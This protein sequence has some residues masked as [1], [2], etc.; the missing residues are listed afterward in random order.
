MPSTLKKSLLI[1]FFYCSSWAGFAQR[2]AYWQQSVQYRLA[3]SLNDTTKSLDGTLTLEYTNQSPDTLTSIWF[4]L[5][6]NAYKNDRTA[7][8]D[9]LLENGR[10]DFYF[11]PD[12]QKGYINQLHFT[13]N[14]IKAVTINQAQYPDIIELLLPTPLL[15]GKTATINTPFHVQLP[16]NFS[17]GGYINQ[18][19][20]I[21]QWYPKP[22]VYD[23]KGWHAMPYLDQ[24]EFYSEFGDYEV[25]INVPKDYIVAATGI[26]ENE[27]VANGIK[28]IRY[29]QKMAHDFAWFA[30]KNFV[31]ITDS[32]ELGQKQV[33][34]QVYHYPS[35]KDEWKNSIRY[36]K[37]ALTTKSQWLG[38]YPYA[39]ATVVERPDKNGGGM[40]YPTI[41]LISNP[42][43]EK[44]LDL[45]IYHE[46]GHNWF[47]GILG[48][49][50]RKYP[51][52]D[53]G[54]NTYYDNRYEEANYPTQNK[55]TNFINKRLPAAPMASML[56]GVI[57][58][59]K[60]QAI[61]NESASF[62]ALNYGLIAYY[63][64]GQWMR[65][66]ER[67]L[68][69]PQFDSA[70]QR[71]Y[72]AWQFKHPYPQDFKNVMQSAGL[73]N[74]DSLFALLNKKGSIQ[75]TIT[76]SWK[77]VGI[78]SAHETHRYHY[79]GIAPAIGYNLYDR[80]MAGVVL[81][82][83]TF[84]A[85]R[86]QF[87]LSP[88][89]ATGSK[90]LNGVANVSFRMYPGH[91]GQTFVPAISYMHFTGGQ[92]TDSTGRKNQLPF[93]KISPSLT[94]RFGNKNPKST[95]S[96]FV[97]WKTSI[98][99]ETKVQ[100]SRD[101]VLQT[102]LIQYP[103]K[104]R[105]LHQLQLSIEDFRAL[106]PYSAVFQA[107]K[108]K[109]FARIQFTGNYFFNYP[110]KGGLSL[111]V[112]AGKF[113]YTGTKN[114]LT[115]YQTDPYHLNLSGAKGYED[116]AYN[117][118]F[119]GR[120]EYE[121][122][123]NQQI[124]IRD[125]GFKVRTDL[126]SQKIGKTDNWLAAVNLT[127]TIPAAFNPLAVLP[128]KLP[129]RLFFDIGTYAE[130]WKK[131]ANTGK[132]L[133]D[134]GIQLSLFKN[135]VNIYCPLVYSKVYKDYFSSTITEKRFIKNISFSIDL[136]NIRVQKI[137]PGIPFN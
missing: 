73:Q 79:L 55:Q 8:S 99:Q 116:F 13:V 20:Q 65:L 4:H 3:V 12:A 114:Y 121:G 124:M 22:A 35:K 14:E 72:Q 85:D 45:L 69:L 57:R 29:T 136:Q 81:H 68:G 123:A 44:E 1:V 83:Y 41:T 46:I 18:S 137:F 127:S 50:E 96:T 129:L 11:S 37:N 23:A 15:P 107:D 134:G 26:K 84:P 16:Y 60:D 80:W 131:N 86:F 94:Y 54:M 34:L 43:N 97:R 63:K 48:S 90:Q 71:Y 103:K 112:F 117:N 89:Y 39:T 36:L 17:R 9:Q 77:T 66:L 62:S 10:T 87:V 59:Q 38:T 133:Y 28:T 120:N 104:Q 100:F 125:G 88:M 76:R 32:V 109:N 2:A 52:M 58:S 56:E 126:L 33:A 31:V 74:A 70:M 40:E 49:N 51:W 93:T 102:N 92:F 106:Y 64:T 130:A 118:Y 7:F 113:F 110:S 135:I 105:V 6:P 75:P 82:N 19:F 119:V 42:H 27:S 47:Y 25:T 98:I 21:T 115:A 101:T 24:G 5:W 111:R 132:F 128:I 67:T 30:D 91:N 122:F 108:G 53:E 78:F 61:D 95:L